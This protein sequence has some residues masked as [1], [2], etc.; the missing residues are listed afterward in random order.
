MI[1]TNDIIT[2]TALSYANC[3]T[4]GVVDCYTVFVPQLIV[5]EVAR[6]RIDHV[7]R[8]VAYGTMVELLEASKKRVKPVCPHFGKCGG[9]ALMHMDYCEQLLFK[10]N[11]VAANLRKIGKL[12]VEV[13]P[14]VPSAK[15]CGY[16]NKLSLPVSG[17]CGNV[18][19]GMYQRNSH[20]VVQ[21]SGCSLG[22]DWAEQLVELFTQYCNE[23]KIVPYNEQNFT[24]EVRHLVARYVDGQLLVTVVSNGKFTKNLTPFAENLAKTFEKF[25]LF[26][27]IND[28][29]NNVILGKTTKHI[30]GLKYIEGTHLGVKFRL[31]PGSFF[32]VNDGV[33][34]AIYTKV[35]ELLDLSK[36]EV[37][38]DCF[39]GIG[40]LTNALASDN[41]DTY[42][43][44]IEPSAVEDAD[45]M[46]QLN[47]SPRV[48]NICGDVNVELP[49]IVEANAGKRFTVV[50]DPPRK[51][52]GAGICDTLAKS[53]ADN[54]VYI[55][56][57]SATL[58][59]DLATL[60]DVYTVSYVQPYDMFPNTDQVETVALL[61]RR[62]DN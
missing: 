48:Q 36:T 14:C 59:R 30:C 5:G 57:D 46:V 15:T 32:Q 50:V 60:A 19:V 56:C 49:K 34:D 62:Q 29:K 21:T 10:Q 35:R 27:N 31:R 52:L 22:G 11:K 18:H 47:K 8:N 40:I 43:I 58:A 25:G 61:N 37:L 23:Y 42:A 33:K 3:E 2:Y 28:Y 12:D 9:C 17:K 45:E 7:K 4:V 13:R 6:V 55:S 39:S 24:G 38:V 20:T 54:V 16:R 26:V 44:E 41:Y 51:G 1:K 53:N